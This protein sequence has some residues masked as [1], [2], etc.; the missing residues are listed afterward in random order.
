MQV[1]DVVLSSLPSED[2]TRTAIEGDRAWCLFSAK[3]YEEA[4]EGLEKV[5]EVYA[6]RKGVRDEQQKEREKARSKAGIEKGEGVE[7]GETTVEAEE[8]AKAWWRLGEC[9]W[10]LG[11]ALTVPG[12]L[13]S[14]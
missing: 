2:P 13:N 3:E 14:R 1:W 7:E 6:I 4:V 5:V 9:L 8:R 12:F 10:V 11:G